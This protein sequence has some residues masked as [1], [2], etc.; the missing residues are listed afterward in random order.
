VELSITSLWYDQLY[1]KGD[2]IHTRD[3]VQRLLNV[4]QQS[5]NRIRL[6][7]ILSTRAGMP[8]FLEFPNLEDLSISAYN[9]IQ[10]ETPSVTLQKI[11]A[12]KLQRFTI[13][14]FKE[15]RYLEGRSHFGE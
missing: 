5:L 2:P 3:V 6:G 8:D 7:M 10:F 15:S 4:H 12:P 1:T 9:T 13:D 14:F 11:A